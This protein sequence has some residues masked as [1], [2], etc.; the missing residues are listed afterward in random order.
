MLQALSIEV[1]PLERG[2]AQQH[3]IDL[4]ERHSLTVYDAAYLALA[5]REGCPLATLD[6][7]LQE[8]AKAAAVELFLRPAG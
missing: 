1:V 8:A 2:L 4:G 3:L 7:A 6:R 5:M